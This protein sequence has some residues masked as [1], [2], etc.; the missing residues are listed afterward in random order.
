MTPLKIF[1]QTS[2]AQ[3]WARN[4]EWLPYRFAFFI[5]LAHFDGQGIINGFP[6]PMPIFHD[7]HGG[8]RRV[9]REAIYNS[10]SRIKNA[11]GA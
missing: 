4:Y 11:S 3:P 1:V 9:G 10:V 8:V 2:A 6:R 5:L 7:R